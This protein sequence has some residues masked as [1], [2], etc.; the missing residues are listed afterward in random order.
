M[1]FCASLLPKKDILDIIQLA[2]AKK[3]RKPLDGSRFN[4]SHLKSPACRDST[5][6]FKDLAFDSQSVTP[7]LRIT[8][9]PESVRIGTP[10][11][12]ECAGN[13]SSEQFSENFIPAANFGQPILVDKTGGISEEAGNLTRND[14]DDDDDDHFEKFLQQHRGRSTPTTDSDRSLGS[15]I[16]D[17]ESS[18]SAS[19][20]DSAFYNRLNSAQDK[21]DLIPSWSDSSFSSSGDPSRS[22]FRIESPEFRK[23]LP[24]TKH[25]SLDKPR[26]AAQRSLQSSCQKIPTTEVVK[27]IREDFLYS[28]YPIDSSPRSQSNRR[29]HPSAER[30]VRQFKANRDALAARLFRIYNETIF[31]EK[32]PTDLKISWNPRLLKTAGQCKYL[33]R[34]TI[35]SNGDKSFARLAEIELSTKVCTSAERVRDT[36]LHEV[37]HAAVWIFEG[38]NDGHG[39]RWRYWSWKSQQVWPRLPIVSVCHAY[40][41]DTR[42]TYRCTGCGACVNRHSKSV[43]TEKQVCGRCHSKFEL[44]LNTPRGRMMRPSLAGTLDRRL[45]SHVQKKSSQ[46]VG[47]SSSPR[48]SNSRSASSRPAFA[49]FVQKN[50]KSI[51]R[52]AG[53][54]TH[55]EAMAQLGSLFRTMKLSQANAREQPK[56]GE[57]SM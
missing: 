11:T 8:S 28:L 37:C 32:L 27:P 31:E 45:L 47:V 40:A 29:R 22:Q 4:Q 13:F 38:I 26:K 9:S 35:H 15:F 3:H 10:V 25:L 1:D 20:E 7:P 50:Y 41:I 16:N 48:L 12:T 5:I 57:Q 30:F 53:V 21:R 52:N 6:L 23:P 49:D 43:N 39:P 2:S 44:L 34:Q 17:D 36:L 33:K 14:T 46:P 54:N 51:R 18:L 42:F 55:A 24:R 19:S 56:D